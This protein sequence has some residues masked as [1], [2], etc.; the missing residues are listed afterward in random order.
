MSSWFKE[1]SFLSYL[2]FGSHPLS[3]QNLYFSCRL[4]YSIHLLESVEEPPAESM[5]GES[6][7][8]YH[9]RCH[10]SSIFPIP[11]G[12]NYTM[13]SASVV[14]QKQQIEREKGRRCAS[15]NSIR[16]MS[17]FGFSFESICN[18]IEGRLGLFLCIPGQNRPVWYPRMIVRNAPDGLKIINSGKQ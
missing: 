16:T 12:F 10:T 2:S 17:R 9:N 11:P 5:A 8:M 6:H 13:Y 7:R 18:R 14:Q 3:S 15:Y 1:F 4:F